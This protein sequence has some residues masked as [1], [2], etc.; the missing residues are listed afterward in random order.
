MAAVTIMN[1]GGESGG[2]TGWTTVSGTWAS[3]TGA[4]GITPRTGSRFIY[5]TAAGGILQQDCAVDSGGEADID[6]GRAELTVS[7]WVATAVS[8]NDRALFQ[9]YFLD[10]SDNLIGQHPTEGN[11]EI[12]SKS[13][14]PGT[15]WAEINE[16]Y[17][18]SPGTRKVRIELVSIN[19]SGGVD[20]G[21]DDIAMTIAQAADRAEGDFP[22]ALPMRNTG[23]DFM[24]TRATTSGPC[25]GSTSLLSPAGSGGGATSTRRS[26]RRSTHRAPAARPCGASSS[27]T[28]TRSSS[29]AGSRTVA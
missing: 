25:P 5:G 6:A 1:P 29:R 2:L 18:V 12:E 8:N 28:Y 13:I 19:T 27:S 3:S 15:T 16:T 4:V 23:F 7:V 21:F 11:W 22:L 9:I 26:A 17:R 10:G 24:S 14:S 20:V